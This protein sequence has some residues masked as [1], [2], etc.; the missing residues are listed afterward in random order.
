MIEPVTAWWVLLIIFVV[1]GALLLDQFV[2]VNKDRMTIV[3]GII[4]YV[5]IFYCLYIIKGVV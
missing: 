2:D 5:F 4:F 3:V 1:N